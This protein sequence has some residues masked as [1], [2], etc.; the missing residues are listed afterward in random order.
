MNGT[1]STI[2]IP[3]TSQAWDVRGNPIYNGSIEDERD[4]IIRYSDKIVKDSLEKYGAINN[5]NSDTTNTNS[6]KRTKRDSRE[7]EQKKIDMNIT[8]Y[9]KILVEFEADFKNIT[10]ESTENLY[11]NWR[12]PDSRS[13]IDSYQT[14][15]FENYFE[16]LIKAFTISEE[17]EKNEE[18]PSLE[19]NNKVKKR[20]RITNIPVLSARV[21]EYYPYVKEDFKDIIRNHYKPMNTDS[22]EIDPFEGNIISEE[23]LTN[24]FL[25]VTESPSIY[26][27]YDFS[28]IL[29]CKNAEEYINKTVNYDKPEEIPEALN[30]LKDNIKDIQINLTKYIGEISN[31][32]KKYIKGTPKFHIKD[33]IM[34]TTFQ[35]GG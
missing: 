33:K 23:Q 10:G 2:G 30:N 27:K 1:N 34:H 21:Y 13:I 25:D 4:A 5:T 29:M 35:Y 15:V 14:V 8:H 22:S 26:K 11:N 6:N 17:N 9:N 32:I 24:M 12:N 19:S 18:N 20:A 31:Q 7:E 28:D 3:T 16:D